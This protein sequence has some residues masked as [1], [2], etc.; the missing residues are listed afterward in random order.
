MAAC[1]TLKEHFLVCVFFSSQDFG[2]VLSSF[3][4]RR[5]VAFPKRVRRWVECVFSVACSPWMIL[6]HD[7]LP[8]WLGNRDSRGPLDWEPWVPA[9]G[10]ASNSHLAVILRMSL[11][12]RESLWPLQLLKSECCSH[13]R[14]YSYKV[15]WEL[16]FYQ[17]RFLAVLNQ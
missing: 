3:V 17:P 5:Q 14:A 16:L 10:F 1:K 8:T 13:F 4:K 7:Q 2:H 15:M 9:T 6:G 11:N 12:L